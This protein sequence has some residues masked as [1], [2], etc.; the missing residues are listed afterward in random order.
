MA[1]GSSISAYYIACLDQGPDSGQAERIKN[2]IKSSATIFND[3]GGPCGSNCAY[4]HPDD[5]FFKPPYLFESDRKTPA[6]RPTISSVSS[7]N[8]RVSE[9]ITV[10]AGLMKCRED[11]HPNSNI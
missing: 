4:N 9:T 1:G 8:L 7:D 2:W 6:R 3:E 11:P 10:T 5:Q